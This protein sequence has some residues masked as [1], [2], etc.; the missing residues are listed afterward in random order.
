MD[1]SRLKRCPCCGEMKILEE[2]AVEDSPLYDE[3]LLKRKR[4]EDFSSRS[5]L[6]T[7]RAFKK[8]RL[9]DKK[10]LKK[11]RRLNKKGLG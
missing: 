8:K 4:G 7:R 11:K 6:E 2:V 5:G 9:A 10:A 1:K 3:A